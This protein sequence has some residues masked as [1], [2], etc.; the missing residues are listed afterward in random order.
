MLFQPSFLGMESYSIH[1]TT[2]NSMMSTS[3]ETCTAH[4]VA[5]WLH[6]VYPGIAIRMQEEV[7]ALTLSWRIMAP[8]ES[9]YLCGP[10]A[11]AGL[12]V[13]LPSDVDQ[14]AGGPQFQLSVTNCEHLYADCSRRCRCSHLWNPSLGRWYHQ[15]PTATAS[16]GWIQT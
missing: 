5:W 8:T 4:S 14:Q 7:V 15:R 6:C 9:K 10:A 11:P 12:T 3:A 2:F 1:E 16:P 13:Q